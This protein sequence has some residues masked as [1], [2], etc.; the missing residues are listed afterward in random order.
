MKKFI[1]SGDHGQLLNYRSVGKSFDLAIPTP[2]HY[3]PMLYVLSL[4]DKND[5]VSLF[6]DKTVGGSISMTC[7]RIDSD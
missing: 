7:I 3:L 4:Q 5:R 2:E 6:N 1:L